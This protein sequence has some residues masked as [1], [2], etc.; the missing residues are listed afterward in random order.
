MRGRGLALAL[1]LSFLSAVL[2]RKY[3]VV[4]DQEDYS[5][6]Q[7]D[8]EFKYPNDDDEDYEYEWVTRDEYCKSLG[9]YGNGASFMWDAVT[10]QDE[11]G[12]WV[13]TFQHKQWGTAFQL[14]HE[15]K[16]GFVPFR[17][18]PSYEWYKIPEDDENSTETDMRRPRAVHFHINGEYDIVDYWFARKHLDEMEIVSGCDSMLPPEMIL[19]HW[20]GRRMGDSYFIESSLRMY[21]KETD[22]FTNRR[23]VLLTEH[24]LIYTGGGSDGLYLMYDEFGDITPPYWLKTP[25]PLDYE[26]RAIYQSETDLGLD[27]IKDLNA[28]P[29]WDEDAQGEGGE[30]DVTVGL[31]GDVDPWPSATEWENE[32]WPERAQ[33]DDYD[34]E[35]PLDEVPDHIDASDFLHENPT[36]GPEDLNDRGHVVGDRIWVAID[37]DCKEEGVGC[38]VGTELLHEKVMPQFMIDSDYD[39]FYDHDPFEDV[40]DE[41]SDLA[42]RQY[43]EFSELMDWAVRRRGANPYARVCAPYQWKEKDPYGGFMWW[44]SDKKLCDISGDAWRGHIVENKFIEEDGSVVEQLTSSTE[45]YGT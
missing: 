14:Y 31:A 1:A 21:D 12:D 19:G 38:W 15:L 43:V 25:L 7:G 11:F 27:E 30:D 28:P 32:G 2:A 18:I 16:N 5:L 39:P 20:Q 35:I 24:G 6:G 9:R 23:Q 45:P 36:F 34:I 33:L 10:G 26:H 22:L 40:Q 17:Y 41:G 13:T 4:N 29:Q 8:N 42:W 3:I 44:G 37:Y